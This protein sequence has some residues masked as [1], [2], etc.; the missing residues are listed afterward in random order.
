MPF[1]PSRMRASLVLMALL[2]PAASQAQIYKWVDQN[3]KTHYSNHQQASGGTAVANT[4]GANAA[5]AAA[6]ATPAPT[7]Q[8]RERDY[9]QRQASRPP[10][11]AQRARAP[12]RLSSRGSDQPDTDKARCN[13]ARDVLSRAVAHTNGLVTDS[14]DR[15]IAERDVASFCR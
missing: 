12:R 1:I 3:G 2:L 6:T 13:L 14:N 4:S 11:S 10:E 7:W 8:E 5:P 9:Q 15:Q